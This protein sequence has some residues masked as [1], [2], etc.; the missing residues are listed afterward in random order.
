[1]IRVAEIY[2]CAFTGGLSVQ[3]AVATELQI[4]AQTAANTIGEARRRGFLPQ[5]EKRKATA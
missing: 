3:G 2:K 4:S 1:M 5:T